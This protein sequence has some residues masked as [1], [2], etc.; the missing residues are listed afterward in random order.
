MAEE[1]TRH[2]SFGRY[3]IEWKVCKNM[4]MF[5]FLGFMFISGDGK[6]GQ[7]TLIRKPTMMSCR[8]FLDKPHLW[9]KEH[10]H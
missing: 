7:Y 4:K 6:D 8:K 10:S 3:T 1:K 5:N 2:I 9:L